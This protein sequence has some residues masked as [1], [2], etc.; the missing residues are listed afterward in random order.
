MGS[1]VSVPVFDRSVT[2]YQFLG[3]VGID[4]Y[5]DAI[6][7]VFGDNTTSWFQEWMARS[8]IEACPANDLTEC[9]LDAL[10]FLGGGEDATCG[11]C[12]S[13]DANSAA[14]CPSHVTLL[15]TDLWQ[16]SNSE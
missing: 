6:Q 1:T 9:Q 12:N 3:V 4:I 10:R 11:A 15:P 5:L 2:P 16:N 7:Q 13:T 14:V 8:S